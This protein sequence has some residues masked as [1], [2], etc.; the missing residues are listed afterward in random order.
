MSDVS[1]DPP[2]RTLVLEVTDLST[3]AVIGGGC[4]VV[5]GD[6]AVRSELESWRGVIEVEFD[7]AAGRATV[8]VRGDVP[9]DQDLL[10]GIESVGLA[11]TIAGGSRVLGR[12]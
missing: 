9:E 4:C 12:G 7:V 6:D 8:V 10:D 1:T 3:G 5:S 2:T 11:A